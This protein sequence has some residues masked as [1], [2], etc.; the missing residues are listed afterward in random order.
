MALSTRVDPLLSE[1]CAL[2]ASNSGQS[3]GG[4]GD[5]APV[6]AGHAIKAS[7]IKGLASVLHQSGDKASP[8]SLDKVRSVLMGSLSE[9]DENVRLTVARCMGG[10][11]AFLEPA[12]ITDLL[13]DLQ[14]VPTGGPA[15]SGAT[16]ASRV[17][18]IAGA[19]QC[20][21]QRAAEV[22]GEASNSIRAAL[23]DER[24]NVRISAA[25]A[26]RLLLEPPSYSGAEER[27]TEFKACAVAALHLFADGI[28]V[29]AADIQSGEV[30]K[31]AIGAIKESAKRYPQAAARHLQLFV[32]PLMAALKDIN[33]SVK[34]VAERA[35]KYL[36]DSGNPQA[37]AAFETGATIAGNIDLIKSVR[38]CVKYS[39]A[40]MS[41]ADS[42]DEKDH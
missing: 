22:R 6:S 16:E 30:R 3:V 18:A 11:T 19:L 5:N 24:F 35:L 37:L 8:A 14:A 15:S 10:V 17:L 34:Y 12:Q 39:L 36:L 20:S 28:S 29:A 7:L 23:V 38:D 13:L 9:D 31:A 26:I 33:I 4:D 32:P 21:G 25:H 2:C 1:L 40:K 27:R 41:A 42:D